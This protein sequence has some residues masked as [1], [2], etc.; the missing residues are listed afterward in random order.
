MKVE[1]K[2]LQIRDLYKLTSAINK[3]T[4]E[5]SY[6]E[7]PFTKEVA[8]SFISNYNTWGIWVNN[9][10]LVGAVEVKE[11]LET[12]YFVHENWRNVGIATEALS[13]CKKHFGTSQLWCVINPSNEASL[14]VAN[15]ARLRVQFYR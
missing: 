9:G 3:D 7:W 5:A 13:Q 14:R 8:I 6:I 11:D 4:A 2:R 1:L 10:M 12:A 15:K